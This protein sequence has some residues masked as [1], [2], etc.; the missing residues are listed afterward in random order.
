MAKFYAVEVISPAPQEV[1]AM[2]EDAQKKE[3]DKFSGWYTVRSAEP[4]A[5]I[6][7]LAVQDLE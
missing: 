3:Q 4:R 1:S 5:C 2:S 7:I 6:Q